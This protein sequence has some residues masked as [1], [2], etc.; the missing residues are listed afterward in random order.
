MAGILHNQKSSAEASRCRVKTVAA[1]SKVLQLY[2]TTTWKA[3]PVQCD[4]IQEYG[5]LQ[6]QSDVGCRQT[7]LIRRC[8]RCS[9][10]P[11]VING[12]AKTLS[13]KLFQCL[14]INYEC[15]Q[16]IRK[17]D[18]DTEANAVLAEHLY[19]TSTEKTLQEFARILK[20]SGM[21]KQKVLGEQMEAVLTCT[22]TATANSS[23][24]VSTDSRDEHP[25]TTNP[26]RTSSSAED[27]SDEEMETDAGHEA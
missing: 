27:E 19:E 8:V 14:V 13:S 2:W 15:L 17:A 25:Q 18:C 23:E 4:K 12:S 20:E 7:S 9:Q 3:L 5:P 10:R 21:P 1:Y 16:K 22:V 11:N 24:A 6:V 26:S